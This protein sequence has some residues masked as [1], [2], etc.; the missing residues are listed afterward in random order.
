M[1]CLDQHG[2]LMWEYPMDAITSPNLMHDFALTENYIVLYEAPM[3]LD[4]QVRSH[5]LQS[6]YHGICWALS[7]KMIVHDGVSL[8]S[9]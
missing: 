7:A 2:H 4:I 9:A 3:K 6:I 1:A 5:V 8:A